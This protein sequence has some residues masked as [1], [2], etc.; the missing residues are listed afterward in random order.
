MKKGLITVKLRVWSLSLENSTDFYLCFWLAVLHSLSHFFFHY[1]SPSPLCIVFD[2]I[3]SISNDLTQMVI[4]PI[5]IPDCDSHM[6]FTVSIKKSLYQICGPCFLLAF[7]HIPVFSIWKSLHM[8]QKA[9][10]KMVACTIYTYL[11]LFYTYT[12]LKVVVI[13]VF[14][15]KLHHR[16]LFNHIYYSTV[17]VSEVVLI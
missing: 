8:L 6:E 2:V 14:L 3:F 16:P 17:L 13:A 5:Q 9:H 11:F 7:I 4:F 15:S 10:I 1:W 12:P